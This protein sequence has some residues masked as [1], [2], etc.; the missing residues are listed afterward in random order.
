M[1]FERTKSGQQNRS[2]F[3][4]VDL[5]CYVEGGGGNSDRSED[6][7]FWSKVFIECSPGM[8]IRC[9]ARGG[10]PQL[11]ELARAIIDRNLDGTLVAMDSDYD[12]ILNEKINDRRVVYTFGYSWENDVL[13]LPALHL[14]YKEVAH[15]QHLTQEEVDYIN[16]AHLS[17][18]KDFKRPLQADFLAFCAKSSLLPRD[19]PGRVVRLCSVTMLPT[20][21]KVEILRICRIKNSTRTRRNV[22]GFPKIEDVARYCVGHVYAFIACAI[23]RAS[24]R[25]FVSRSAPSMAHIRQACLLLLPERL[26]NATDPVAEHYRRV[27]SF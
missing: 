6:V 25:R 20:I 9:V 7:S 10:K 26:R 17:A 15:S 1:T 23:V 16:E 4:G 18:C 2:V 14:C 12:G 21:D 3:L 5:V 11:E 24:H 22:R 27:C 13:S 8:R 19:A